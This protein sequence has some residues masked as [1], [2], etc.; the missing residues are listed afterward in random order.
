MDHS[1]VVRGHMRCFVFKLISGSF[2][3][4][5]AVLDDPSGRKE[6]LLDTDG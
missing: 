2:I 4:V 5:V 1:A 6:E 3:S